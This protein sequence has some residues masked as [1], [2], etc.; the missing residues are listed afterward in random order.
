MWWLLLD[1][2]I[3]QIYIPLFSARDS[4]PEDLWGSSCLFR[5][6]TV[7]WHSVLKGKTLE[8]WIMSF[9]VVQYYLKQVHK[10][11]NLGFLLLAF[12]VWGR[13][14]LIITT[15]HLFDVLWNIWIQTWIQMPTLLLNTWDL[16]QINFTYLA[17]HFRSL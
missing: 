3:C 4:L 5:F 6:T 13:G 8:N 17:S 14:G 11:N 9:L 12:W 15:S 1:K 7:L 10:L 2:T 16:G